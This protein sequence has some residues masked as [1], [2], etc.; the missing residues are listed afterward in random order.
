MAGSKPEPVIFKKNG[1]ADD[2]CLG[3]EQQL[4]KEGGAQFKLRGSAGHPTRLVLYHAP[5]GRDLAGFEQEGPRQGR[6]GRWCR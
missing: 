5:I 1:S 3:G 4:T 2:L 6:Q